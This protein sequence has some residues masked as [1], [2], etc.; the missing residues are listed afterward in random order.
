MYLS[1]TNRWQDPSDQVEIIENLKKKS[2]R[3]MFALNSLETGRNNEFISSLPI[4]NRIELREGNVDLYES[5]TK[6][7]DT[8]GPFIYNPNSKGPISS[9]GL[10]E[11][12][13]LLIVGEP[14][15]FKLVLSNPFLFPINLKNIHLITDSL[16]VRQDQFSITLPPM[17]KDRQISLNLTAKSEGE[18]KIL[19]FCSTF[20]NV[21]IQFLINSNGKIL[22]KSEEIG[23]EFTVIPAQAILKC[24]SADLK[25]GLQIYE[26]ESIEIPLTFTTNSEI[27]KIN[28][29][30]FED[31]K[32]SLDCESE[33]NEIIFGNDQDST[34]K[35]I[36]SIS[37]EIVDKEFNVPLKVFGS[38]SNLI[39]TGILEIFYSSKSTSSYWRKLEFPLS[40][41]IFPILRVEQVSFFPIPSDISNLESSI[42]SKYS[43]SILKSDCCI[44]SLIISNCDPTINVKINVTLSKFPLYPVITEDIPAQSTKRIFFVIPKLDKSFK[45]KT[46][47]KLPLN[48]KQIASV[49]KLR[50]PGNSDDFLDDTFEDFIYDHDQFWIKKYLL[51]NLVLDWEMYD[52]QKRSGRVSLIHCTVPKIYHESI[53]NEHWTV[54]VVGQSEFK[55]VKIGQEIPISI[56]ICPEP[57]EIEGVDYKLKLFPVVVLNDREIG[58]NFDLVIRYSGCLDSVVRNASYSNP[59]FR[60]FKFY[61]ITTATVKIIYQVI[62]TESGKVHW[63]RDPIIIDT[64]FIE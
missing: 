23:M 31:H 51:D 13:N 46:E 63:C 59:Q 57:Q 18:I 16:E 4:F 21:E 41:T 37:G 10:I 14:A 3:D 6:D 2:M 19:G 25:T 34:F 17:T 29:K 54:Q 38:Y 47:K 53:F 55:N 1:H 43:G 7:P 64:K 5:F 11:N 45:M 58:L 48:E 9:S 62:E 39:K 15:T 12:S 27:S 60:N 40:V 30:I 20:M 33:I 61:P 24:S 8:S 32:I 28:F 35:I 52:D 22:T 26:G 49:R 44:G 36:D 42:S 50:K 56:K